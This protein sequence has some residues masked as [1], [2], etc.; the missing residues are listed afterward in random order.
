M[1]V[2][3]FAEGLKSL[4][5][6]LDKIDNKLIE[7]YVLFNENDLN[8]R[9][10]KFHE[11]NETIFKDYSELSVNGVLNKFKDNGGYFDS[12]HEIFSKILKDKIEEDIELGYQ[13]SGERTALNRFMEKKLFNTAAGFIKEL[14]NYKKIYDDETTDKKGSEFNELLKKALE[15]KASGYN[16]TDFD[17]KKEL[18]KLQLFADKNHNINR[19]RI[20]DRISDTYSLVKD[21][22]KETLDERRTNSIEALNIL[23]EF[24]VIEKNP[25]M[26]MII[27]HANQHRSSKP[28][29]RKKI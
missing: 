6:A 28:I 3:N 19:Y 7:Y 21:L 12:S 23:R 4:N 9:I 5:H 22:V 14:I 11:V 13:M 16:E 18:E 27:N 2:V 8:K 26:M 1:A 10:E 20:S 15:L 17:K 25:D 24:N 29:F